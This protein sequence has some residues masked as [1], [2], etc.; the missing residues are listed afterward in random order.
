MGKSSYHPKTLTVLPLRRMYAG[1]PPCQQPWTWAA[2]QSS[3]AR[4]PLFE[5]S[6]V[7]SVK[8]RVPE[9]RTN[10]A[11]TTPVRL[12]LY[13]RNECTWQT[14][15]NGARSFDIKTIQSQSWIS[16]KIPTKNLLS[17]IFSGFAGDTGTNMSASDHWSFENV[18]DTICYARRR[19]PYKDGVGRRSQSFNCGEGVRTTS[20]R[21]RFTRS[22]LE[23]KKKGKW[24]ANQW[25]VN[26]PGGE[27]STSR[28][29]VHVRFVSRTGR[30]GREDTS[31]HCFF[32]WYTFFRSQESDLSSS[33]IVATSIM[34]Q[35]SRKSGTSASDSAKP[36]GGRHQAGGPV[37]IMNS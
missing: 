10:L 25:A 15:G 16:P 37:P 4:P 34:A 1:G 31:R 17:M 29:R 30:F 3:P 11:F 35:D 13:L 8:G 32:F 36:H 5:I 28:Y 27:R 24:F 23:R 21:S 19:S 26:I 18:K 12:V 9:V 7:A 20:K 33:N 2:S 14:Q 6:L 22:G